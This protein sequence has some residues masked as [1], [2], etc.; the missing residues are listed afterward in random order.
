M[1]ELPNA[2]PQPISASQGASTWSG[3]WVQARLGLRLGHVASPFGVNVASLVGLALRQNPRRAHLLVSDVLGKHVPAHPH[4]VY[5]VG[6]VLGDLVARTLSGSGTSVAATAELLGEALRDPEIGARE[7]LTHVRG[8][9]VSGLSQSGTVVI[10]YAET[11]T[12]LGHSVADALGVDYLHS[13]RRLRS[14]SS[15]AVGFEEEHSHAVSHHLVPDDPALLRRPGPLVLVDDELTTGLT[16][17]NTIAEL[18]RM[19]H[20][21]RYVIATLVD[22]RNAADQRRV[23]DTGSALGTTIEVVAIA[24]GTVNA[25]SDVMRLSESLL[26][27]Q[28]DC[29]PVRLGHKSQAGALRRVEVNW[30]P[31]VP[32]GGRHGFHLEDAKAFAGA[33]TRAAEAIAALL[34]ASRRIHVLGFEELMYAP[35]RIAV[36]LVDL[37]PEAR[38]TFSTTTRSPALVV[39]RPGYAI[40]SSIG[41][42]AHDRPIDGPG[43][44]FAYNLRVSDREPF[45]SVVLIIDDQADTAELHGDRGILSKLTEV[46]PDRLLAVLPIHRPRQRMIGMGSDPAP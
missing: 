32:E 38:V 14:S 31:G 1:T 26:L 46:A 25:P 13:T 19:Q 41:F 28:S 39:D 4:L 12:A 40:R 22:L 10:G 15:P 7:F 44:R 3:D 24:A 8:T 18:Q 16:A 43:H 36:E 5:A 27:K 17:T 35:M 6:L 37:L 11:A 21:D 45:D 30:P 9:A 23:A 42:D 20:R 29:A 33:V 2:R 34:G